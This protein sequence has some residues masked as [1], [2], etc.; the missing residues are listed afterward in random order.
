[1]LATSPIHA[2]FQEVQ[3]GALISNIHNPLQQYHKPSIYVSYNSQIAVEASE[4][5]D[6]A[7]VFSVLFHPQFIAIDGHLHNNV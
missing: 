3:L 7:G 2:T 4:E 6:Q 5:H 1:M